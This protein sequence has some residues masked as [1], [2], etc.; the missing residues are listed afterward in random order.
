MRA[1]FS[2][3]AVVTSRHMA[4][5]VSLCYLQVADAT[6]RELS[7]GACLKELLAARSTPSSSK[8]VAA[9]ADAIA[10][11]E[12]FGSLAADVAA[13]RV[14]HQQ[15][16][17]RVE[18]AAKLQGVIDHV[19]H[20]TSSISTS[21]TGPGAAVCTAGAAG[22]VAGSKDGAVVGTLAGLPALQGFEAADWEQCMSMLEAAVEEA[23]DANINAVRVSAT[24][25]QG[26]CLDCSALP[27]GWLVPTV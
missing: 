9:L 23:K 6:A 11:A 27:T 18:A 20:L 5:A 26:V 8:G 15:C 7:A 21:G 14:L 13:A 3:N 1:A 10:A 25:K 4:F 24:W 19:L 16:C 17:Q 12:P 22:G 2:E